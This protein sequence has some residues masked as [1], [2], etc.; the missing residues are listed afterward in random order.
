MEIINSRVAALRALSAPQWYALV[1]GAFLLIRG[2]TTLIAGA[3][4]SLPGSGW[5]AVPQVLVA[6]LLLAALPRPA[7]A[8]RA[9]LA[10]GCL[11]AAEA[12]IGNLDGGDILGVIPVDARDRVVH[13]TLAVL[14]LLA[15]LA[16]FRRRG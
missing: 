5:R 6:L 3:D 14:A 9:V 7:V 16:R 4:F 8:W 1:V 13:P 11:Y 12:V 10:V 15:V 2:T